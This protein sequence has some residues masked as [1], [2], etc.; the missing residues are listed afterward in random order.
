MCRPRPRTVQLVSGGGLGGSCGSWGA[1]AGTEEPSRTKETNQRWGARLRLVQE[2]F[3]FSAK[4]I[5]FCV[6]M[7]FQMKARQEHGTESS[8]DCWS[9]SRRK[10]F[11]NCGLRRPF[12]FHLPGES[13]LFSVQNVSPDPACIPPKSLFHSLMDEEEENLLIQRN[14]ASLFGNILLF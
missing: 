6:F 13:W 14:E 12:R 1:G 7:G 3:L 9:L 8:L 5:H 4:K 10:Y 2:S 11:F